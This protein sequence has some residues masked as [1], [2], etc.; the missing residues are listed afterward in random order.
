[1]SAMRKNISLILGLLF[2]CYY[3]AVNAQVLNVDRIRQS[4]TYW[5]WA[6]VSKCVL[7]YYGKDQEQCAIAEYARTRNPGKFGETDCCNPDHKCNL[8]NSM[9]DGPGRTILEALKAAGNG[10]LL[11]RPPLQLNCRIIALLSCGGDGRA[12]IWEM[13]TSWWGTGL[14]MEIY[15]TWILIRM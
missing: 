9:Y 2:C 15:T 4:Q 14:K 13:A 11:I 6:A 5:C 10:A 8:P 1:M 12:P 3:T 7:K